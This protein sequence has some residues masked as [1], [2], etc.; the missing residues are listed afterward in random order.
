MTDL[1]RQLHIARTNKGLTMVELAEKVGVTQPM[2]S[3]FEKGTKKPGVELLRDIADV[4]EVSI[5]YLLSRESI[6]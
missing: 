1:G 3:R 5:D 4:L 6:A 2:I